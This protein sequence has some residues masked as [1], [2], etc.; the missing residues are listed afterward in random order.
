MEPTITSKEAFPIIGIE[1]KTTTND[2][3]NYVEI[4]QFWEKILQEG[5]IDNIP[6]RK[7]ERVLLGICMDFEPDDSFSYII[8]A[9]VASTE[10]VPN[11]MISRTIPE[12]TYAVFTVRGKMPAS[13]QDTFKFIYQEWLP[14]SKY[15]RAASAEF[16][17]YDER[18][19]DS[20]NSEMDI[21]IPIVPA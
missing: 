15:Q 8:G 4:P 16:E 19:N 5:Q 3:R 13:I 6:N 20:E 17:L 12:A 14:T 9:E 1:L 18:F 7:F 10:N 21:F 11:D 2:G